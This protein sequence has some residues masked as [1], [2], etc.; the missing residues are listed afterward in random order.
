MKGFVRI[1]AALLSHDWQEKRRPLNRIQTV[2][3]TQYQ[4]GLCPYCGKP[5]LSGGKLI[6][7][8]LIPR[9][10]HV[11]DGPNLDALDNRR[12]LH[13]ECAA[14][15]TKGDFSDIARA[16]R[17]KLFHETGRHDQKTRVR[18]I[19]RRKNPWPAGRKLGSRPF[20]KSS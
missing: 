9:K 15:K 16:K 19:P 8:H 2:F 4:E 6:D 11:D 3:L 10:F 1:A 17:R 20:R 7:E 18:T 13:Q 5:L 12:L 14:E